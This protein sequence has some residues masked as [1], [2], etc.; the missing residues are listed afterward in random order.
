[1]FFKRQIPSDNLG[2]ENTPTVKAL[3]NRNMAKTYR[4]FTI[5]LRAVFPSRYF[6]PWGNSNKMGSG[7]HNMAYWWPYELSFHLLLFYF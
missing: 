3:F 2:S 1:M 4:N 6:T 7:C 5:S